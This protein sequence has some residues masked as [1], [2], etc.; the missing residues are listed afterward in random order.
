MNV[1]TAINGNELGGA[2]T[3]N[4]QGSPTTPIAAYE[5]AAGLKAKLLQLPSVST[6]FVTRIDPTQNCDDGLC[7]NGPL[8]ARGMIWTCFVTTDLNYDDVTPHSPTSPLTYET[9]F[10]HRVTV[11]TTALTGK[12]ESK[13]KYRS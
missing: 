2:Y 7:N 9:G 6:A 5:S 4:F 10:F 1:S 12:S 13:Y 11:D 3:L 8:A